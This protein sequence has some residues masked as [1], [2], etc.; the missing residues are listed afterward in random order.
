LPRDIE[1]PT[2]AIEHQTAIAK[3]AGYIDGLARHQRIVVGRVAG[4]VGIDREGVG[5]ARELGIGKV[6]QQTEL[7]GRRVPAVAEQNRTGSRS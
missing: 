5:A 4:V 3:A 7:A 6:S 2:F 1:A